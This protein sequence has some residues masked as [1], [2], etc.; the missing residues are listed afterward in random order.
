MKKICLFALMMAAVVCGCSKNAPENN[1]GNN[2]GNNNEKPDVPEKVD[3]TKENTVNWS[4]WEEGYLDIHHLSTGA[5]DCIFIVMPDGTTMMVDAGN[6]I[7][8]GDTYPGQLPDNSKTTGEW[9][10]RYVEHFASEAGLEKPKHLDYML[11]THFHDDHIGSISGT[12]R[13]TLSADGT[14]KMTGVSRVANLLQIDKIVD[15]DY[16]DYCNPAGTSIYSDP[17]TQNYLNFI[18]SYVKNGG[19]VEK[20][21]VGSNLQFKTLKKS[22]DGFEI[23]NI[24]ST[25]CYWDKA[26]GATASAIPTSGVT[27]DDLRENLMSNVIKISYGRFDYHCGGD[28]ESESETEGWAAVEKNVGA[29]VGETDV[30]KCDHHG[31]EN[32]NCAV[33]IESLTP[34][35]SIATVRRATYPADKVGERILTQSQYKGTKELYTN[36]MSSDKEENFQKRGFDVK[37]SGHVVVRV[38]PAGTTFRVFVF[39]YSN[40]EFKQVYSSQL[41]I[42]RD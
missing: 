34:Q 31:N 40:P 30:M 20:F 15:R 3:E 7:D 19:K 6:K 22:I 2:N 32:A 28:I 1:K 36:Y 26:Y 4:K 11:V 27:S 17:T 23:R 5:G 25:G 9:I 16:P 33:F 39:D 24:Y 10:A 18:A 12:S 35:V 8:T 41:F 42:S 13:W 37:P 21:S 38:Y 29:L 14:Y